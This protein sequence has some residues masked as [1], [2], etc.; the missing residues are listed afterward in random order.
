MS[1]PELPRIGGELELAIADLAIDPGAAGQR[2]SLG[3][4][5]ERWFDTGRSA[6]RVAAA[7]IAARGGRRTVWIPAYCC[8]S[9]VAPFAREG[10][11]VRHYRVGPQ[12]GD[13]GADPQPGDTL[14]FIHY[15]GH[16][17]RAAVAASQAWRSAGVRVIEDCVQAGLTASIGTHGDHAV[18]SLRKL[19][20]VP[21]GALLASVTPVAVDAAPPSDSFVV[22]RLAAKLLRGAR[23]EDASYLRLIESSEQSLEL[24]GPRCMS[25]FSD[26]LLRA[27]DLPAAAARRRANWTTLFGALKDTPRLRGLVPLFADL[28]DGEVP[29]GLPVRVPASK[30]DALR[31]HLAGQRIYCAVHWPLDHLSADGFEAERR[32]AAE[33]LTLPIDQR[34][35]PGDLARIIAALE[36]FPGGLA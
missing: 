16:R 2:P 1:R 35:G 26:R 22:A 17:N 31:T 30:R 29:L 32:L 23:A 6:L 10:F 7:D 36:A 20:P 11:E 24:A 27:I 25:W 8:E 13:L 4:P 19:L 18:T 15:F 33:V 12:L 28:D 34:Y 9:A 5:H 21:D 14:L 3:A